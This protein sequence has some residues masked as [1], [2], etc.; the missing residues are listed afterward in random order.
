MYEKFLEESLGET[1][2][3]KKCVQ[4]E[5]LGKEC[6]GEKYMGVSARRIIGWQRIRVKSMC[7]KGFWV[8]SIRVK[9]QRKK[10]F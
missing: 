2:I 9:C 5:S 10:S 3:C 1:K 8:K 4:E 7:N 6:L